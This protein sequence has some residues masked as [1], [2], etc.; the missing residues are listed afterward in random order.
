MSQ[1][2]LAGIE[3]RRTHEESTELTD[4]DQIDTVLEAFE[5]RD[6]RS[7]LAATSDVAL[8]VN[9]LTDDSDIAQSTAYRKVEALVDAGLLEE[10]TRIRASGN[11]VSAYA[12]RVVDVTLH[13]DGETGVELS[14]TH[15]E[16]DDPYSTPVPRY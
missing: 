10:E 2:Q 5:D 1:S 9:E 14:L 7:I 3:G 6:C 15:T 11:H 16:R 8:T 12:S 4:E 13:V